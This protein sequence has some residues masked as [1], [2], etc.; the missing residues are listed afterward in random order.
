MIIGTGIDIIETQ[1]V[2][3]ACEKKAFLTRCFTEREQELIQKDGNKAA[4]NFAAKEAV[5]K[6]LGTGFRNFGLSDIEILRDELGK[7]Y[8]ILY[9]NAKE[10][11]QKL[12]INNIHLSI[13]NTKEYTAAYAI[14]ESK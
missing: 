4:G 5:S 9:G 11:S 13:S 12:Q 14:G 6:V 7:P 2:K 1:R 10:L 3:R 8:V